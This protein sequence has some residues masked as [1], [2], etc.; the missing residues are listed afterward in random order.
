VRIGSNDL[1]ARES[2]ER[3]S[4]RL[5]DFL[6]LRRLRPGSQ[7]YLGSV[8]FVWGSKGKLEENAETAPTDALRGVK[9]V[10]NHDSG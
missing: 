2:G 1:R 8:V 5:L 6:P 10:S 4:L 7:D 9:R 3:L